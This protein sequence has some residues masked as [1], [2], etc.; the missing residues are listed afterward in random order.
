MHVEPVAQAR[1]VAIT[2]PACNFGIDHLDEIGIGKAEPLR[3]DRGPAGVALQDPLAAWLKTDPEQRPVEMQFQRIRIAHR[4][5]PLRL[6]F[7][8]I[9]PAFGVPVR[10]VLRHG[11]ARLRLCLAVGWI[12]F[13][14]K[15]IARMRTAPRCLSAALIPS[16]TMIMTPSCGFRPAFATN[17]GRSHAW[18]SHPVL[19]RLQCSNATSGMLHHFNVIDVKCVLA[20][21]RLFNYRTLELGIPQG[22]TVASSHCMTVLADG[23]DGRDRVPAVRRRGANH[24]RCTRHNFRER[25]KHHGTQDIP[26]HSTPSGETTSMR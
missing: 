22:N 11:R 2:L 26:R 20:W 14:N 21:L 6:H 7:K 12:A 23:T 9:A 1:H 25:A 5:A 13:G 4:Q 16:M 15:A 18:S 19:T 3:L 8:R 10:P 17:D 24:V